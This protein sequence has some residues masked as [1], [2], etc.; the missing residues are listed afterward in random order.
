[1]LHDNVEVFSDVE[2]FAKKGK[3]FI[4][5]K[6]QMDVPVVWSILLPYLTDISMI[7]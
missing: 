2:C 4:K 7:L 6:Y 1:M 5:Q 3:T